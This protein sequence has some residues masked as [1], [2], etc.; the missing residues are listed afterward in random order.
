LGFLK[1][2]LFIAHVRNLA[3]GIRTSRTQK[4]GKNETQ[5]EFVAYPIFIFDT[6]AGH[7]FSG[8]GFCPII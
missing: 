3:S 7:M 8:T 1:L 5:I 2:R 4:G 6:V